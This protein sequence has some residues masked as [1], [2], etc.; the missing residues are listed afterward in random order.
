MATPLLSLAR[1]VGGCAV[2]RTACRAIAA[3]FHAAARRDVIFKSEYPE[4]ELKEMSIPDYMFGL[5]EGL[6]SKFGDSVALRMNGK[7]TTYNQLK[8]QV[9]SVAAGLQ[10]E[11]IG[12]GSV[13]GLFAQN[14]P[15]FV[16]AIHGCLA[17]GAVVTPASPSA[18]PWELAYQITDSGATSMVTTSDMLPT[19][20]EANKE[21]GNPLKRIIVSGHKSENNIIS[22][23]D[24]TTHA[25]PSKWVK[26][27]ADWRTA[28]ALVPYSSGTTGRPKGVE[29]TH[30]NI[31]TNVIQSANA[32]LSLSPANRL[33]GLLP[34]YHAY[35]LG[36]IVNLALHRGASISCIPKFEPVE[37]LTTIQKDKLDILHVVPPIALFLA[38]HP[39]VDKFDLSSVREIVCGAA[40]LSKEVTEQLYARLPNIR[41]IRQ[42][43]GMTELSPVSHF[44]HIDRKRT[45]MGSGG[46]LVPN[47][48]CK[49]VDLSTGKDLPQGQ[50]GELCVK[51]PQVMKGYHNNEK[52][53]RDTIDADGWLHTGD[54]GYMCEDGHLVIEDRV[55]ELI[56]VKGHQVAPAELEG[57]LLGHSL[58]GDV[59]VV[60]KP[61]ERSG[62]RPKAY[63]VLKQGAQ[64]SAEELRQ[65]AN[66]HVSEYKHLTEI[67]FVDAIPKTPSGKILR[68][69][70]RDQERER[71]AKATA[72]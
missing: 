8:R 19:V 45:Q 5:S 9:V 43:Y 71:A 33:I 25:D 66:K 20:L 31:V 52:A 34:F 13:V 54:I 27:S 1:S 58:V 10:E 64:L 40:P 4:V 15:T 26:H 70:L 29:L 2:R 32:G 3:R 21:S 35:G 6:T 39:V 50:S 53:T 16:A 30:F 37:F 62:E 38:K 48:F 47:T 55:K 59:C 7:E 22:F 56:K 57:L 24:L 12:P 42:G 61:D 60:Q 68:R 36:V 41:V 23:E 17:S 72:A 65:W 46:L 51:G 49:F 28:T 67:E 44:D 18:T 69:V 11:G 63:V 14:S